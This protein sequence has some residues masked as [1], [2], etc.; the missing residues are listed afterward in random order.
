MLRNKGYILTAPSSSSLISG[1][2]V[3]GAGGSGACRQLPFA[4]RGGAATSSAPGPLPLL[5]GLGDL[6]FHC[7]FLPALALGDEDLRRGPSSA[8]AA[9]IGGPWFRRPPGLYSPTGN[10]AAERSEKH[11]KCP[12]FSDPTVTR[13]TKKGFSVITPTP[14]QG[15]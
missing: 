9:P 14:P 15:Q 6:Q 12:P 5:S 11:W 1:G 8:G 10:P 3:A 13:G 4:L 2:E 7:R